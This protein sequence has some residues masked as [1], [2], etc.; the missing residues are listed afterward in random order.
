MLYLHIDKFTVLVN[1]SNSSQL[2][3]EKYQEVLLSFP[4]DLNPIGTNWTA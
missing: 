3:T 4:E 1:D 2:N